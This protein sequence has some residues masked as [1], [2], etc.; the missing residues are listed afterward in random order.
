MWV[1]NMMMRSMTD[2]PDS[3]CLV[4]SAEIWKS[5]WNSLH[6]TSHDVMDSKSR[7]VTAAVF[8]KCFGHF[9]SFFAS[10]PK[11]TSS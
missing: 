11:N 6:N 3:F 5:V 10:S 8:E 2:D 4:K 1:L 7:V 9:K